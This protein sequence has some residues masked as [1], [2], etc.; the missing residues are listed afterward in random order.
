MA[1]SSL[2]LALNESGKSCLIVILRNHKEHHGLQKKKYVKKLDRKM[3]T[4]QKFTN[5]IIWPRAIAVNR[6]PNKIIALH[7]RFP[8]CAKYTFS[9]LL[10]LSTQ[11]SRKCS[12]MPYLSQTYT[13]VYLLPV[14][15]F[16][17]N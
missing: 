15:L 13:F 7:R 12:C 3:N 8:N 9:F 1:D 10:F 5:Y 11:N 17:A 4:G 2:H 14:Y 6:I 16:A